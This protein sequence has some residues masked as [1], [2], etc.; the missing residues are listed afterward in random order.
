VL[1][2]TVATQPGFGIL[3]ITAVKRK[4]GSILL[5][6]FCV[7]IPISQLAA[8]SEDP[9][10]VF[11]KAYMTAQ[12]GEKLERENQFKEALAKYRFAGSLIEQL[13][14]SHPDWQPAI[15]D[16]RGRKISESILRVQDKASTQKE[17]TAE[18]APAP[19]N[20]PTVLENPSPP[21]QPAVEIAPP[22]V[23]IPAEQP[24]QQ[25]QPASTPDEAAIQA[26]TKK[27]QSKVDEL[28]AELQK[29][30]SQFGDAQKEKD[31]LNSRLKE[32]T[33][34]LEQA[35]ND[36]KES[37][38]AEQKVRDQLAAAQGTL[39]KTQS[40]GG[41]D[42]KAQAA[43]RAEIADL[44]KALSSV[45]KGRTEAEHGRAAAE[46]ERD[47]AN[48]KAA[49]ADKKVASATKERDEALAQ[50]KT[51][52]GNEQRVEE[53]VAENSTLKKKLADA[54]KTV[55]EIS[56]DKPKREK[57]L[58]DV[59]TQIDELRQQLAASQ[60]QNKDYEVKVASLNSQLDA[61][62]KQLEKVKL[63]G[64]TPEET[65]KL[66]KENE[67]LRAIIVRER[68]EEARREQAKKLMLAEFQKLDIKSETLTKQIEL[69]AQPITRLTPDE[70]AL[71]RQP[72]VS[73]SDN[74]PGA[75]KASFTFAKK[76]NS[77]MDAAKSQPPG[78][79]MSAAQV[80]PASDLPETFRPN[81]PDNVLDLAWHAKE[82]FDHGK[83]RTAERTYQEILTKSPNN[84]YS[85]SNL[86]VVYFR[87]G[88]LKAAE[89][90]LK[91]AVAIAPKDEFARTTL[92]IVYYREDKFDN[93]LT[94]LT[95]ALAINPKSA[96]AHN[97]LGIT[98]SQ[99][100]WQEAAE[101]EM[102]EAVADNPN[103]ADA[104]FNL[105]VIYATA[106]PPAKEL[107]RRHYE[108]ATELGSPPDPALEKLLH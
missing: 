91:K 8:Q 21:G 84:L 106:Q 40:T 22:R 88:K 18:P 95:K 67:M 53:L 48:A 26:A 16:Y 50:L 60:K 83:Y 97:Y 80:G 12:Q 24:P 47:L 6:I 29:A 57:E 100:G 75:L 19:E 9:S 65:A 30:H 105:A 76:S 34:K 74:N 99:K 27:L 44:K 61:A 66:T 1:H 39:K 86:G 101:K 13:H 51:M 87:T 28:E 64:A 59:K 58:A 62:E 2:P 56:E 49:A 46:K 17:L 90:T 89:L 5:A 102:L 104:H 92:G 96:T 55:Q 54:E 78:N 103:Y 25:P 33:S 81:V 15:V 77:P 52:K 10:D 42:T 32:T 3:P 45:E 73:I 68:Q 82:S 98:A 72:V 23:D 107:A 11:L 94:E 36:L 69:L 43:L 63:T 4:I 108:R 35:Q 70:L 71:L 20:P 93:A 38:Q 31:T 79:S 37:K 7:C 85:L 14:K 41:S